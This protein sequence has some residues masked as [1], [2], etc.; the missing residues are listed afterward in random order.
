MTTIIKDVKAIGKL[1]S[2]CITRAKKLG[3]DVHQ[4][5]LSSL[6]HAMEHGDTTL[7]TKLTVGIHTAVNKKALANWA[8]FYFPV[9]VNRKTFK[10]TLADGWVKAA[11]SV[12]L[13]AADAT[14]FWDFKPAPSNDSFTVE[15]LVKYLNGK[16]NNDKTFEGTKTPKV[17]R[18]ARELAKRLVGYIAAED[19]ERARKA[20]EKKAAEREARKNRKAQTKVDNTDLTSNVTPAQAA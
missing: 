20:A 19:E 2:S 4:A 7:F 8:E 15:Q 13:E 16:A 10:V 5:A 18:Q 12:D 17:T 14:P 1:V 11:E 9:S 6:A 3:P